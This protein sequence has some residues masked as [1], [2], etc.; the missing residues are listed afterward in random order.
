[1]D[2]KGQLQQSGAWTAAQGAQGAAYNR[3][4]TGAIKIGIH[5]PNHNG[6]QEGSFFAGHTVIRLEGLL[7]AALGPA[8]LVGG[9][10]LKQILT[11]IVFQLVQG[12]PC[13]A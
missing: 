2:G 10:P 8:V 13:R 4:K 1:M 12:S 3:R 5:I 11:H 6:I 9:L 7:G